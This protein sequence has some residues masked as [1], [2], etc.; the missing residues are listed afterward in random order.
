MNARELLKKL[1]INPDEP[2]LLI[3]AEEALENILDAVEEY[4]PE[5]KIE[6]MKR[7]EILTLL[8]SYGGAVINYRPEKYHQERSALIENFDT[9]KKYGLPDKDYNSIDFC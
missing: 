9:L 7:E 1:N 4:C 3:T 5:L 6:E 8:K 2:V